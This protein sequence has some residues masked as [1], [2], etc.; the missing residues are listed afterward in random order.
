MRGLRKAKLCALLRNVGNVNITCI[1][2][3]LY[4]FTAL[5]EQAANA[6]SI[7]QTIYGETITEDEVDQRT[8]LNRLLSKQVSRQD[9]VSQLA[10]DKDKVKEAQK[11]HVLPPD[12]YI[13]AFLKSRGERLE[14]VFVN[15][16]VSLDTF[17]SY[18]RADAARS[19][20]AQYHRHK[21]QDLP[22]H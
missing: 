1:I 22:F 9:V 12:E 7:A 5:G 17:R 10:D 18:L 11:A 15:N 4:L 8:K 6:Q 3:S 21:Y 19:S 20:L 2:L 14:Q 16:G 13:E